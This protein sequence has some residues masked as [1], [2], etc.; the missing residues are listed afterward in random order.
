MKTLVD[1]D[2]NFMFT[3]EGEIDL[4]ISEYEGCSVIEG[5][6]PLQSLEQQQHQDELDLTFAEDAHDHEAEVDDLMARV[7]ALEQRV[8]ELENN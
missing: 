7:E 5:N 8:S 3:F 2:G 1:A 6:S 4:T